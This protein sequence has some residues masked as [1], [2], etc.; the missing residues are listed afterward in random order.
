MYRSDMAFGV[1]MSGA[2][3]TSLS[4]RNDTAHPDWLHTDAAPRVFGFT[5]EQ[6]EIASHWSPGEVSHWVFLQIDGKPGGRPRI[7]VHDPKM[8]PHH[9]LTPSIEYLDAFVAGFVLHPHY[10]H[11]HADRLSGVSVTCLVQVGDW[12]GPVLP[13]TG[14]CADDPRVTLIPDLTFWHKRGYFETREEFRRLSVPWRERTPIAYWRGSST[15]PGPISY[16]TFRRLPRFRL[17]EL[18][19]ANPVGLLD[20]R[21]TAVP[22]NES[23]DGDRL[24]ELTQSLGMMALPAKQV[25]F[26]RY[27][28]LIDIDGNT[29]SWGLLSKLAMG[30]C[31][32]KVQSHYRQWYYAHMHPWEHYVPVKADL[33]DLEEKILW[34]REH[35]DDARHIA[36]AAKR[37]VNRLVFGTEM[38]R[39]AET[40]LHAAFGE[41][42]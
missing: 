19:L 7:Y 31:I 38:A 8:L 33:S 39:A 12:A 36:E 37:F 26:L 18:S 27:R 35:D 5:A 30:S 1:K 20:A 34:C 32:L 42:L 3:I 40:L 23:E 15:G 4:M 16:E 21:L 28:Y 24:R 41:T 14:F 17:C 6:A 9:R 11:W 2:D 29:N 22:Q 10:F 25:A 13:S